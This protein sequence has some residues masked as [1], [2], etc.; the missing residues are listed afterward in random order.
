MSNVQRSRTGHE[1]THRKRTQDAARAKRRKHDFSQ[2]ALRMNANNVT[3]NIDSFF[4]FFFLFHFII[5]FSL[6]QFF[7]RFYLLP[8]QRRRKSTAKVWRLMPAGRI[9]IWINKLTMQQFN[10]SLYR[11]FPTVLFR[12][13][14]LEKILTA[15]SGSQATWTWLISIAAHNAFR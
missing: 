13:S 10:E 2:N 3:L 15:I 7:T 4:F 14:K 12:F 8:M 11:F 1:F 9:I 5:F 6:F